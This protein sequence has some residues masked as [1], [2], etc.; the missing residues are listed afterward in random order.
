[1]LALAG[2]LTAIG[3]VI[4]AVWLWFGSSLSAIETAVVTSV[5]LQIALGVTAVPLGIFL[6]GL[7]IGLIKKI[8]SR[9]AKKA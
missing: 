8:A 4:T 5:I 6:V 7:V 2:T 3:D 9:S 1:M